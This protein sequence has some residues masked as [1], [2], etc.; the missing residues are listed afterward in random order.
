MTRLFQYL[1]LSTLFLMGGLSTSC[2]GDDDAAKKGKRGKAGKRA[3]K[4]GKSKAGK[5]KAGKSKAGRSKGGKPSASGSSSGGGCTICWK[6]SSNSDCASGEFC[7]SNTSG[8]GSS[9][10][11]CTKDCN[12]DPSVCPGG[13]S[14]EQGGPQGAHCVQKEGG[15]SYPCATD[16]KCPG[17]KTSGKKSKGGKKRKRK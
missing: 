6:C 7:G 8:S 2:G 4:V 17:G 5:S 13:S 11:Y 10:K 9:Y 12:S 1:L 16:W 3:K 15:A 14:C